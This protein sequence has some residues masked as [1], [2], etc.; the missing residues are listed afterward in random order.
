MRYNLHEEDLEKAIEQMPF[1]WI[2]VD[3]RLPEPGKDV[4]LYFGGDGNTMTVGGKYEVGDGWYSITDSE[5]YT[6]CDTL[7]IY[8]MPLPKPPNC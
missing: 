3:E 8:W 5:Y 7:P 2:S 6:D 4:L 1:Q